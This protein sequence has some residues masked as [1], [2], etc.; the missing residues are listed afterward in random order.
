[1]KWNQQARKKSSH[2]V[3]LEISYENWQSQTPRKKIFNR[4]FSSECPQQEKI[5]LPSPR[6]TQ[7]CPS[8]PAKEK[9]SLPWTLTFR[10]WTFFQNN[11]SQFTTFLYKIRERN[12]LF[13]LVEFAPCLLLQLACPKWQFPCYSW[14]NPFLLEKSLPLKVNSF[15]QQE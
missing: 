4:R 13:F 3:P 6:G 1:M 10:Q 5:Y 2:T 7:E 11:P 12:F 9:G 8:N 14:V 15:K